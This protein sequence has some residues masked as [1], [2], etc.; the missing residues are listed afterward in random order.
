M[1]VSVAIAAHNRPVLLKEAASSVRNQT[2]CDHELV[3]VDDG[4][5][6]P[7][8]K[9]DLEEAYGGPVTLLRNKTPLGVPK[10]KNRAWE[11]AQ[12]EIITFLDDD[13][14]LANNAVATIQQ[15]FRRHAD[16]DCVFLRVEPFGEHAE[17]PREGR[18]RALKFVL[19]HA[20]SES[21]DGLTFLDRELL[22]SALLRTVPIDL[23]RPAARRG[24]WNMIGGFN[25]NSLFSESAWSIRAAGSC[26][27]ALTVDTLYQWRIHGENFGRPLTLT[28]VDVQ[29]RQAQNHVASADQLLAVARLDARDANHRNAQIRGHVSEAYFNRAFLLNKQRRQGSAA[30]LAHAFLLKP[31]LKHVKLA[32]SLMASSGADAFRRVVFR[33]G[34][35]TRVDTSVT[36]DSGRK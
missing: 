16:L 21:R 18:E 6:P 35:L 31:R 28:P 29:L 26:R 11:A 23:Q 9:Q 8:R 20:A 34:P 1:L 30:D 13:D 32:V 12:G 7:L 3:V 10:A 27:A 22:F 24:V 17:Q 15:A 5:T 19:D 25:E 4:S 36:H 2:S 14:R 33:K